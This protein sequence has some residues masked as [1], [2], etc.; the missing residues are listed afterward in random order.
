LLFFLREE[1]PEPF[2]V[3]PRLEDDEELPLD[4]EDEYELDAGAAA[5]P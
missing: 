4:F 1:L 3:P 2:F 5:G